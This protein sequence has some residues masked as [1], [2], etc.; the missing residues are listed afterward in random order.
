MK[1]V[2]RL[3]AGSGF[4]GDAM[5]PAM[6]LLREG[7]LDGRVA[8]EGRAPGEH[9]EQHDSHGVHVSGGREGSAVGLL[10]REI[11]G[12]ADGG[13]EQG[14]IAPDELPTRHPAAQNFHGL[15]TITLRDADR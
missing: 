4:W 12:R 3:G 11:S 13:A 1:K 5:D 8:G 14:E 15:A 6:E 7:N 9:F 10:G 2:V